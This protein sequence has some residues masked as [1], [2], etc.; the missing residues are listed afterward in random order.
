[1]KWIGIL[2]LLAAST[3]SGQQQPTDSPV[4]NET[5]TTLSTASSTTVTS[6]TESTSTS[7]TSESTTTETT[8]TLQPTLGPPSVPQQSELFCTCDLTIGHCDVSCCCDPDCSPDDRLLFTRCWAPPVS[9]FHRHYCSP[10]PPPEVAWN[11]TAEL[12]HFR[13]EFQPQSGLFCIIKDN[14]PKKKLYEDMAPVSNDDMVQR[15][16]PKVIGRWVDGSLVTS[17]SDSGQTF[18]KKGAPIFVLDA[19]GAR[20]FSKSLKPSKLVNFPP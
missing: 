20:P 7:T 8:T 9:H 16:L 1:M 19:N 6:T 18:Y 12:Q 10:L 4:T 11:N 15:V 3:I 17:S 5:T 14:V 13:T 2:L